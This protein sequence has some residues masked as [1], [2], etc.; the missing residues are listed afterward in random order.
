MHGEVRL[1]VEQSK[2]LAVGGRDLPSREIR[3]E[4]RPDLPL[5]LSDQVDRLAVLDRTTDVVDRLPE[6]VPK[7]EP[8]RGLMLLYESEELSDFP[9]GAST[10]F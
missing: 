6:V 9:S 3:G 5:Q 1:R 2:Q 8:Q 4:M 10:A 7:V